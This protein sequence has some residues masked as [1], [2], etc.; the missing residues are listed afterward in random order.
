MNPGPRYEQTALFGHAEPVGF[1][2]D[3]FYVELIPHRIANQMIKQHHY[4]GTITTYSTEHFGVYIDGE[5]VGSLQWGHALNSAS[6]AS[7]VEGARTGD[8][9]ELN[10][11][12]LDD[13]APRNSESMAISYCLKWFRI[14]RRNV[15]WVQ[16]FADERCGGLGVVYQACSF[17][18]LGEHTSVF[19]RLDDRWYHNLWMTVTDP[20]LLK[21]RPGGRYL[22]ANKNRAEKHELRQ[23]RYFRALT[24]RAR[25][26]LLMTPQPYPKRKPIDQAKDR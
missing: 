24:K 3:A 16:S 21:T 14:A 9:R 11:M 23:F 1:G 8:W 19:W 5:I 7:I 4:S 17:L 13:S 26:G 20:E 10:R 18:Y 2:T 22:Q 6:G 25:R 12:W 15:E